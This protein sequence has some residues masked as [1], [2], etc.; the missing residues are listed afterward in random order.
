VIG[1]NR[2]ALDGAAALARSLGLTAAV[3]PDAL[4]G[5]A[6][7]TGAALGAQLAKWRK[8]GRRGV[9]LLAGGETT[10]RVTGPGRGGRCQEVAAGAAI[11]L[12]GEAGVGL[13]AAATDGEDGP[14]DAAGAFVD[15]A[16]AA[17]ARAA[18]ADLREALARNDAYPALERIGALIRTGPTGTNVADVV[19][20]I[21]E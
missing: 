7:Q 21:I 15:G 16:S 19:V 9:C 1:T 4:R 18:G 8:E 10:V 6:R 14:T 3:L 11:A 12:A 5:E 2:T 20:G 13:L 17:A